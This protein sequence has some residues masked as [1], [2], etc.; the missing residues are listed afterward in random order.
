MVQVLSYPSPAI[1]LVA[2]QQN[3][4][5]QMNIEAAFAET[6]YDP[7]IEELL[8][9][10]SLPSILLGDDSSTTLTGQSRSELFSED[11]TEEQDL[12]V[13][14]REFLLGLAGCCQSESLES[15]LTETGCNTMMDQLLDRSSLPGVSLEEETR[16]TIVT[17][18]Y[19]E[20]FSL[21]ST[22]EDDSKEVN[23]QEFLEGLMSSSV[24]NPEGGRTSSRKSL[25]N[26]TT[27]KCN[28]AAK[29]EAAKEEA[30]KEEASTDESAKEESVLEEAAMEGNAMEEN[31]M[32]EN[33]IEEAAKE[34][35]DQEETSMDE[36]A[37]DETSMEATA[38]EEAAKEEA[39]MKEAAM[40]L[41]FAKGVYEER[42]GK[43]V[44]KR[45]LTPAEDRA[46]A[47]YMS[48][49]RRLRQVAGNTGWK[50]GAGCRLGRCVVKEFK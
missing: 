37:K 14:S 2:R 36:A 24:N 31:A 27:S 49:E 32:E 22:F 33:A 30:A 26:C 3:E 43:S 9:M 8:D 11:F 1:T 46:I 6:G 5:Q 28:D 23:S 39:F 48:N 34:E 12:R 10:S 21:D 16:T 25:L 44:W 17:E 15:S 38:M 20:S 42:R 35:A 41:I 19:S 40:K 18:P 29:K 47:T 7:E 50:R 4:I 45:L 13:H